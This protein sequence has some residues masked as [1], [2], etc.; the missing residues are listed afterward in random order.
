MS[1]N[2]DKYAVKGN[3][4]VKLVADELNVP[5]EK[6]GR[7]IRAVLHALRNR[8][9]HE[10]SFQL[11]AQ[12]PM[13]IKG[14]YVD[15]WKFDKVYNRITHLNDFFDE[16]RKEDGDIAG[17]DFGNNKKAEIAI[18]SVF[19]A[20]KYF[21]SDGEMNDVI[22]VLPAEIGHFIKKSIAGNELVI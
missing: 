15:G 14:V 6:A 21:I 10:E 22:G 4:F 13:C 20:L 8:V 18:A 7:V 2:F 17:Y 11:M 5:M 16:A 1:L 3:E 9:S 19:K 12:L